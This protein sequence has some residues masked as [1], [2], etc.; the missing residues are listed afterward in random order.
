MIMKLGLLTLI[1]TLRDLGFEAA[2]GLTCA[3]P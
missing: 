2:H 1:R 3:L